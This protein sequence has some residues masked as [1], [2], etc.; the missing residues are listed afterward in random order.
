M[1]NADIVNAITNALGSP[2]FDPD[3]V[4]QVLAKAADEMR[5]RGENPGSLIAIANILSE[6]TEE[7]KKI[8]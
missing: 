3:Q 8:Y 1:T 7:A 6:I 5:E 2:H 4:I